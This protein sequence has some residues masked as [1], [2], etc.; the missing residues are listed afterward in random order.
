VCHSFS[1]AITAAKLV[2]E[3][4]EHHFEN[5][6]AWLSD[7]AMPDR[8]FRVPPELQLKDSGRCGKYGVGQFSHGK[9]DG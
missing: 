9:P 1:A 2:Y 4:L 6:A 8:I 3:D 5:L 7:V